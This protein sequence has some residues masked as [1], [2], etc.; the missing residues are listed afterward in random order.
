MQPVKY[1]HT[2]LLIVSFS[3]QGQTCMPV[4]ITPVITPAVCGGGNGSI[5]L[6]VTGGT[7]PFTYN[8]NTTPVQT[9]ATAAN[10]PP[11]IYNCVIRD[12]NGCLTVF[13]DEV[14]RRSIVSLRPTAR[15]ATICAGE[16][17]ALSVIAQGGTLTSYTW[18][19]GNIG[20]TNITVSPVVTTAYTI[21]GQDA[22]GCEVTASVP[23]TVKPIPNAAFR[24]TP[25]TVCLGTPQT[26]TFT[27]SAT[28]TA[29]FN[30]NGFAGAAVQS[31]SGAGP[32][33]ILFN[34]AATYTIQLQI[35]DNGCISGIARHPVTVTTAP[36]AA[37]SV[38]KTTICAGDTV[39][40]QFTGS[41]SNTAAPDWNWGGGNVLSG[42]GD[43]P[44]KIKYNNNGLIVCTVRDGICAA[45]SAS[46]A[47]A[48]TPLP[49]AAFIAD[50]ITGC[51]PV[52][53]KF[54][55]QS[56][57]ADFYMW[58]F[59]DNEK[60][61][62]E[63]PVH[64]Y[65][66]PG[67]Y[68][69]T[70]TASAGAACTTIITGSNNIE[71]LPPPVAAFDNTPDVNVP[72]EISMATFEFKNNSQYAHSFRWYFGDGDSAVDREPVH[73]YKQ[74]GNYQVTLY[75][76]NEIGCTDSVGRGAYVVIADKVLLVPN[77]FSPNGDGVH[78]RWVI[79]GLRAFPDCQ[80]TIYN[81]YGQTVFSSRG[82]NE[83][84]DGNRNGKPVATGTYYYIIKKG[85]DKE[86]Y[87]GWVEVLR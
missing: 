76:R 37:I 14:T 77:A 79:P 48:V 58:D 23:V 6:T 78:D 7:A 34:T 47:V 11:G 71:V 59:G 29:V 35:T 53:V 45:A 36:V 82:Y 65:T 9:T 72:I 40:V 30:W 5:A 46:Q 74:P 60:S 26:V 73:W 2:V 8:W 85:R 55:N 70:L 84:W 51:A 1:F 19:P 33:N 16:T 12:A 18:N 27:G 80:L 68:P 42:S 28:G 31:G 3:A 52:A 15:P 17:V 39:T 87:T 25:A 43:G 69:V 44:F 22:F 21:S 63:Q 75:V 66:S 13:Q 54:T 32:Y 64:L 83:P 4:T 61:I 86:L 62:E 49:V 10:L 81:R 67:V 24:V 56:K 38:D 41:K 20:G 50:K 57:Q